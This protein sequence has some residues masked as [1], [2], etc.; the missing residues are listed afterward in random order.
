MTHAPLSR[1]FKF[2]A[3]AGLYV[4]VFLWTAFL[5]PNSSF[6]WPSLNRPGDIAIGLA[7]LCAL[8]AAVQVAV[9]CWAVC[10]AY[11]TRKYFWEPRNCKR[12]GNLFGILGGGLGVYGFFFA[13]RFLRGEFTSTGALLMISG[14]Y[15]GNLAQR[16][17]FPDASDQAFL[18]SLT[19]PM[20]TTR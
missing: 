19:T 16:L 2:T 10:V 5:L 20:N 11:L 3:I 6:A 1:D 18:D 13:T 9:F 15:S 14:L 4:S 8:M 12:A 17:A 7:M